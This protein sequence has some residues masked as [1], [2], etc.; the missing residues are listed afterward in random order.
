M[1]IHILATLAASSLLAAGAAF[2]ADTAKPEATTPSM[3][4]AQPAMSAPAAVT[5]PVTPSTSDVMRLGTANGIVKSFD[6]KTR[7]LTLKDDQS[8]VLDET[9]TGKDL[10][11]DQ[12]VALTFKADGTKKIVTQYKIAKTPIQG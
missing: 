7:T 5:A 2:A 12:A 11:A 8:F 6:L 10:K 1:R 9:L 3:D 4:H